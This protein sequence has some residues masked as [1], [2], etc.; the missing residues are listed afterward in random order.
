M[1]LSRIKTEGFMKMAKLNSESAY[2]MVELMLALS[3]VAVLA[4]AAT[5]YYFLASRNSEINRTTDQITRIV[6]AAEE[7][8]GSGKNYTGITIEDLAAIGTFYPSEHDKT[9]N[10][11][12]S[13]WNTEIEL[14]AYSGGK[15][16]HITYPGIPEAACN[17]LVSHFEDQ[18]SYDGGAYCSD[19]K[20]K[21]AKFN[22]IG[23]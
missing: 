16:I 19:I 10:K 7:W 21:K 8:R 12:Y 6:A 15:L 4:V 17:R 22:Y 2:S 1:Q 9:N 20:D 18:Y 3:V 5:S 23:G 11:I 14:T 13:V